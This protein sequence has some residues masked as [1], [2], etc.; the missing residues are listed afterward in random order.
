MIRKFF[1]LP[2]SEPRKHKGGPVERLIPIS[3][4][5]TASAR[6]AHTAN[7]AAEWPLT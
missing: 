6:G 4:P 2:S 7:P 3:S 1:L 5:D